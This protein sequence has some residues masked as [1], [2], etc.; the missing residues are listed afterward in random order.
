MIYTL[1]SKLSEGVNEMNA[2]ETTETT[3]VIEFTSRMHALEICEH[4]GVEC[5]TN[6]VDDI[7]SCECRCNDCN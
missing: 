3:E 1:V 2:N 4:Y 5:E 7:E 6:E